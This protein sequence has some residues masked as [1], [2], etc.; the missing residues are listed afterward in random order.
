[1]ILRASRMV[2]N[3]RGVKSAAKNKVVVASV[4]RPLQNKGQKLSKMVG[5]K[6]RISQDAIHY[7]G[8]VIRGGTQQALTD[9]VITLQYTVALGSNGSG[10]IDTL[11]TSDPSVCAEWSDYTALWK[12]YRCLAMEVEYAPSSQY[13]P[14]TGIKSIG[15]AILRIDGIFP[16]STWAAVAADP[17]FR[18]LS[19][20][21]PW[22]DGKFYS[23]TRCHPPKWEMNGT[24]EAGFIPT[25]AP[26]S[27]GAIGL[28]ADGLANSTGYGR[29]V[30]R[31][32][33]QLRNPY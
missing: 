20:S 14:V 15:A 27:T 32:L 30:Q 19:L 22:N 31:F 33:V 29:I 26:G 6:N 1:M 2:I 17:S 7:N 12:E 9:L 16:F 24:E 5:G 25:G 23:G 11:F 18:F 10:V 13:S 4:P 8:P 3:K 28:F 21:V